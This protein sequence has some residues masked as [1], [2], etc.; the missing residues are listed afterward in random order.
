MRLVSCVAAVIMAVSVL[1]GCGKKTLNLNDY[2]TYEISGEDG[3]GKIKWKFDSNTFSED[4]VTARGLQ[5]TEEMG[6]LELGALMSAASAIDYDTD[7]TTGLSNGDKTGLYWVVDEEQLKEAGVN[8]RYKD[9]EVKVK[10][11]E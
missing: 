6:L 5:G 7:D 10:G 11:L 9:I 2:V 4:F 8:C 1:A 3:E